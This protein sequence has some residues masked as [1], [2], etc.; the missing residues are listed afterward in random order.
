LRLLP[1][2]ESDF[3]SAVFGDSIVGK[4]L[5]GIVVCFLTATGRTPDAAL[6][7]TALLR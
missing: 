2:V 4:H 6:D 1:V 7:M 5:S 3:R